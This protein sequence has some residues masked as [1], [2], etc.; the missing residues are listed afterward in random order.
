MPQINCNLL[1][2]KCTTERVYKKSFFKALQSDFRTSKAV[3]L[4]NSHDFL[5]IST[6]LSHFNWNIN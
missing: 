4:I 1:F 6:T 5:T 3:I 2:F